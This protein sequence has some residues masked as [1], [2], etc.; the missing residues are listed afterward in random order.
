MSNVTFK[1]HFDGKHIELDE[2]RAWPPKPL[3]ILAIPSSR[4]ET[5]GA[6]ECFDFTPADFAQAYGDNKSDDDDGVVP[7]NL[8][9]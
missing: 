2:P 8:L 6:T 1:A 7:K 3:V 4:A 5:I 9:K